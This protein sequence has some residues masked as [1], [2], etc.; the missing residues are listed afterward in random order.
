MNG[1][2]LDT[3]VLSALRKPGQNQHLIEF[4][5]VQPRAYLHTSAITMAEIRLG[6]ELQS[7]VSRR[8]DLNDWLEHT[9][10]PQFANRIHEVDEDVLLRWLLIDRAGK[11][12]GHVF[13]QQDALIAAIAAVQQLIVVTRDVTHFVAAGVPTLDPWNQRFFASGEPVYDVEN[14]VSATLLADLSS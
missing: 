7:D 4:I 1:F 12:N 8:A 14:L 2:L 6:I 10:R 9:L 3:N 11:N 13:S 5:E